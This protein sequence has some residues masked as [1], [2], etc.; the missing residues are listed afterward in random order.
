MRRILAVLFFT[1]TFLSNPLFAKEISL[2]DMKKYAAEGNS[3]AQYNLGVMYSNGRGVRQDDQQ[4]VNWYT[5]AA[6]QG[7]AFA[8]SRLIHEP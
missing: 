5:K 1:F 7:D 2:S 4:A 6:E 3:N 8:Q